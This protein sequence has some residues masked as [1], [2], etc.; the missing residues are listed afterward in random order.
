MR[1][2]SSPRVAHTHQCRPLPGLWAATS[3]LFVAALAAGCGTSNPAHSDSPA[4]LPTT[5]TNAP[6]QSP[7]AA[8]CPNPN[9]GECL[10]TL[11]A[12]SYHTSAF[13]PQLRYTVPPGWQNMEDLDANVELIPPYS[14]LS[15]VDAGTGDYIGIYRDVTLE[16]GC[17]SGPV[18]GLA[19]TPA[20][21]MKHLKQR[22]DLSVLGL[23]R[24]RVG[25]LS[26]LVAD[27]RQRPTW[28]RTC[29]YSGG[30]P[31]SSVLVG[32]ADTGLDHPV[33]PR[34]T[35]RL[36]L[37]AL[38]RSVVAIEAE[39]VHTAGRLKAYSRIVSRFH[40]NR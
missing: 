40:F 37:L 25:G 23:H 34:Q 39:D 30:Q 6:Q 17:A 18:R 32:L 2:R 9:G 15:Q 1:R 38:K 22:P 13:R 31:L 10:G 26:G 29:P 21:M 36:Y 7:T 35:M 11:T 20:A 8:A 19:H 3:A 24:I 4:T 28:R 33:I 12:G 5:T 16:D 14:A 27:I